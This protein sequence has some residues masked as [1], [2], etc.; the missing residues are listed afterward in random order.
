MKNL[1]KKVF[2]VGTVLFSATSVA[3]SGNVL[4]FGETSSPRLNQSSQPEDC[5]VIHYK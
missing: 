3:N 4:R 2:I 5:D 1:I